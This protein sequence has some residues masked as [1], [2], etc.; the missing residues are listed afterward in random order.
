MDAVK[1]PE[2]D[3]SQRYLVVTGAFLSLVT[4][5]MIAGSFG[6]FFKPLSNE[7]G[8]TRGDTSGAYSMAM[9]ISGVMS[10][11]L[12]RLAGPFVYTM[13]LTGY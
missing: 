5:G 4:L 6:V 11:V 2:T 1:S 7:F 3:E 10:I 12:G 8:W 13:G 9:L